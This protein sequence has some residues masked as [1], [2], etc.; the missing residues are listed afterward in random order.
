MTSESNLAE[1]VY[2][3]CLSRRSV[4]YVTERD[5]SKRGR[6]YFEYIQISD[7]VSIDRIRAVTRARRK[8][9]DTK[10]PYIRIIKREKRE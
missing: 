1:G 3:V 5:V 7:G 4:P 9:R 8:Y 10:T 6:R 2:G